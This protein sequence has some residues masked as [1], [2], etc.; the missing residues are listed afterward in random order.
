MEHR[1]VGASGFRAPWTPVEEPVSTLDT[2]LAPERSD[3]DEISM[4][5]SGLGRLVNKLL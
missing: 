3:S 2:I 5:I 1:R 4:E